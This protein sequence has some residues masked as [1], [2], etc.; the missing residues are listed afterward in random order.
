VGNL[1]FVFISQ[2]LFIQTTV[3]YLRKK[4]PQL[5]LP[6][7]SSKD[8]INFKLITN[9]ETINVLLSVLQIAL[10]TIT[11]TDLIQEIQT[12]LSTSKILNTLTST[13]NSSVSTATIFPNTNL[14]EQT[15]Q[16][17]G[18]I[19]LNPQQLYHHSA[20]F[21]PSPTNPTGGLSLLTQ[22]RSLQSN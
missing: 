19:S 3:Q 12:M 15:L 17:S 8:D 6:A 2:E 14:N 20:S 21:T 1:S 16:R 4:A 5:L 9:A 11:N 22:F 10:P 7:P 13:M 18:S